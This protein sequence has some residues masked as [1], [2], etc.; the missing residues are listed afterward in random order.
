MKFKIGDYIVFTD[1]F[2][3]VNKEFLENNK[4]L[5]AIFIITSFYNDSIY[6]SLDGKNTIG[7]NNE[8]SFRMA[9]EN[10]KKLDE[11]KRMF[12]NKEVV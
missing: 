10:E 5:N 2:K 4:I 8:K 6:I 9:T 11:L 3:E 7:V 1:R 12:A